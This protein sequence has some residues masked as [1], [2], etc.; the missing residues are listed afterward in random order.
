MKYVGFSITMSHFPSSRGLKSNAV[1]VW[2][3][4]NLERFNHTE[5][6]LTSTHSNKCTSYVSGLVTVLPV[7]FS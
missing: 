4:A 2:S 6:A 5:Y 1:N 3:S 7:H